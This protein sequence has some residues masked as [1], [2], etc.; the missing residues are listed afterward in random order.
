[1]AADRGS[2]KLSEADE[3]AFDEIFFQQTEWEGCLHLDCL[4]ECSHKIGTWRCE[5]FERAF[6]LWAGRAALASHTKEG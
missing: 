3:R 2:G 5:R 1:M 4:P 6:E